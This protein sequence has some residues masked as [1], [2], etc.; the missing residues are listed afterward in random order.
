M[1]RS[2]KALAQ[3]FFHAS[4]I[5]TGPLTFR[6]DS[7]WP[8][9]EASSESSRVAE[10]R[11]AT[12]VETPDGRAIS[13]EPGDRPHEEQLIQ[14]V[15]SVVDVPFGEPVSLLQIQRSQ[16]L[17]VEDGRLEVGRVFGQ[18]PHDGIPESLSSGGVPLALFEPVGRIL[19]HDGHDVLPRLGHVRVGHGRDGHLQVGASGSCSVLRVIV[20]PLQVLQA[21]TDGDDAIQM[22]AALRH[23]GKAGQLRQ[24]QMNLGAS[25]LEPDVLHLANE[26]RLEL[27]RAHEV[28]ERP[29]GIGVGDDAGRPEFLTAGEN[30][31]RGPAVFHDHALDGL[32]RPYVYAVSSGRGRQGSG[33]LAHTTPPPRRWSE[34]A[35]V[36]PHV[37][38]QERVYRSRGHGTLEHPGYA[39][40]SQSPLEDIAL[41]PVPQ[42]FG[43]GHGEDP[44]DLDH[45]L[46]A[47][48]PKGGAQLQNG[49]EIPWVVAGHIGGRGGPSSLENRCRVADQLTERDPSLGV[50]R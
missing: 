40:G 4:T 21:G 9:N 17:S 32:A 12:E 2:V 26:L 37:V 48:S 8:A 47:Q 39:G 16:H 44:H 31:A 35:V 41:E 23:L 14:R 43:H 7:Y 34:D 3:H 30:H 36:G 20:R 11:T 38:V 49:P 50:G 42:E 6:Y 45:V 25:A 28:E 46:L 24:Y 19:G 1:A 33:Q 27:R 18:R 29:A 5:S 15:L 22:R 13:G 10:E